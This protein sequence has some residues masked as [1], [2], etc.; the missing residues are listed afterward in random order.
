MKSRFCEKM[1]NQNSSR[2]KRAMCVFRKTKMKFIK[3]SHSDTFVYENWL[4]FPK[5]RID[6]KNCLEFPLQ[7]S[8]LFNKHAL[9]SWYYLKIP[10]NSCFNPL[11]SL[12][13]S[14]KDLVE[15][16]SQ[17]IGQSLNHKL[18]IYIK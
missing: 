15:W 5:I 18:L 4:Q 13:Y 7:I 3:E 12:K 10:I 14:S 9:H 11:Q 8:E 1:I 17:F 2:K 6:S 16:K